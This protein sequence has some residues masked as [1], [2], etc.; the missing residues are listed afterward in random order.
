MKL[1]ILHICAGVPISYQGGIT[2]Y[3]RSLADIQVENG[4]EVYVFSDYEKSNETYKFKNINFY[5]KIKTNYIYKG[6]DKK[7]LTLL[8]K[9]L[10]DNNFDLVHI[11]MALNLDFNFYKE[12]QNVKYVVSLHDYFFIC[13]RIKM[14]PKSNI[15]T[16]N[17]PY[18]KSVNL[19]KCSICV[20]KLESNIYYQILNK[21]Y[22]KISKKSLP[23]PNIKSNFAKE[24]FSNYKLFLESAVCLY[25]V[26]KKVEQI[27]R[28]SGISNV[29]KMLHIGN[30]SAYEFINNINLN[31]ENKQ[32]INVAMIGTLTFEKGASILNFL[33][34]NNENPNINFQFYGVAQDYWLSSLTS[35]GLQYRGKYNQSELKNIMD[36]IDLGL[37]LPVWEDN[38]P[39]VV[40]EFLN[41]RIPIIATKMGG[42]TDFLNEKNSILFDP[43]DES[44]IL[45][46]SRILNTIT[47]RDIFKMKQ[48]TYKTKTP[49]EH[50]NDLDIHLKNSIFNNEK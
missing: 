44:D 10:K 48:Y 26:S 36:K 24:R 27:Y 47:I 23:S 35:I 34:K 22:K 13:P 28:E 29:Y 19:E 7:N 11:H 49:E 1:K 15:R 37:V 16:K 6:I 25:P 38:A 18:C 43:Y 17:D 21:A 31:N 8:R 30:N 3:V 42:I 46:V 2:N 9:V 41:F 39:Q 33:I 12:L 32:K 5:P 45:R 4:Y 50:F 40:M 20:G 14:I